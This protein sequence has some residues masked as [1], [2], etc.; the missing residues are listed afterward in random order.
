M[1]SKRDSEGE[2]KAAF[3][4]ECGDSLCPDRIYLTAAEYERMSPVLSPRHGSGKRRYR[5]GLGNGAGRDGG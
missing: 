4:C 3:L 2:K 1:G 5:R